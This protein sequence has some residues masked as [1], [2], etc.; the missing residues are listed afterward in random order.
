M[1]QKANNVRFFT[2]FGKHDLPQET[3]INKDDLLK[4]MKHIEE[5]YFFKYKILKE[6]VKDCYYRDPR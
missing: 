3:W 4:Y 6:K 2:T 5:H 1:I